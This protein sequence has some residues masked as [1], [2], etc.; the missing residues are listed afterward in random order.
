VAELSTELPVRLV[1]VDQEVWTG[2]AAMV[3]ATTTEGDLGVLPGHA[4]LLGQLVDDS[5]VKIFT[6]DWHGEPTSQ[7]RITGGY[8]SV[9]EDGVS[10]LVES[11]TL[12]EKAHV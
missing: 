3:L 9:T 6:E 4:P 12:L 1:A 11:A 5:L 7:Y 10:I 8:L 2:Q